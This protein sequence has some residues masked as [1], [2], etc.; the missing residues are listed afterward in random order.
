MKTLL[1]YF[2]SYNERVFPLQVITLLGGR[3]RTS[4]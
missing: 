2:A 3:V 1:D 4:T